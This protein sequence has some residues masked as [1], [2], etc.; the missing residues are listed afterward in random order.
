[1]SRGSAHETIAILATF[2]PGG[3][4]WRC[5]PAAHWGK[6]GAVPAAGPIQ[7]LGHQKPIIIGHRGA[8]GALPE[9]AIESYLRALN[10]GARLYRAGSGAVE[11][12]AY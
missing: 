4:C 1:M 12:L 8:S 10:D 3:R 7:S 6:L 9:H 5:L 2:C 11:G